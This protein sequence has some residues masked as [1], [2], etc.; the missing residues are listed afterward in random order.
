MMADRSP[1]T[2]LTVFHF[3][4]RR[5]L[6]AFAQM[7]LARP[8]LRDIPGLRFHRLMGAGRGL[9]FSRRP[10]W[11]RYAVLC[12]W[13]SRDD[14]RRFLD[15]S[16]FIRRYRRHAGAVATVMLATLSAHGAWGGANPFLPISPLSEHPSGPVAVLTHAHIRPSRLHAFLGRL[17]LIGVALTAADGLQASIGI[18]E[19]PFI[20]QATFTIWRDAAAVE[21]FAYRTEGHRDAVRRTRDEGWYAEELFARFAVVERSEIFP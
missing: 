21:A 11:G 9:G 3:S 10:D 17:P 4:G 13:E 5:R 15:D 7:A 12:V 16:R 18:G 8:L 20:L 6:W 1:V 14:A 19:V 2:T